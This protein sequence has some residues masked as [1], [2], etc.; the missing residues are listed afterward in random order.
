[1]S[2]L[3]RVLV[4]EDDVALAQFLR[5]G[6]EL[7]GHVVECGGDGDTALRLAE[8]LAPDLVVLDLGLPGQDGTDVL[9]A[10][11]R[12]IPETPV[13]VLTGRGEVQERVR[14]LDLGADD[15]MLKP[16]S[17]H[18]LMARCRA[19]LRRRERFA[20]PVL[21]FGAIEID[22]MQRKVRYD[23]RELELTGK[24]YAL[25]EVLVRGQG[26]C[27][28]RKALL[29]EVWGGSTDGGTNIVDVY[30]TYLRRKLLAARPE[31]R[32]LGSAIETLR[33]SGYR[34]RPDRRMVEGPAIGRRDGDQ[35]MELALGA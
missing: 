28:S 23:G 34:L 5:K 27:C 14:C 15:F 29:D 22:R 25:L 9:E 4:V 16:F 20:D 8:E 21:R 31:D 10:L 30:V 11:R 18:E 35:P 7:E 26:A 33:G 17:F 6:L 24:E 32:T 3:F 2:V 1:M 13:L 12:R 19:I